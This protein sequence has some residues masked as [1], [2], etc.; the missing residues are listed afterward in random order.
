M[1]S[2]MKST[3]I[4]PPKSTNATPPCSKADEKPWE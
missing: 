3:R 2:T 1:A 4:T